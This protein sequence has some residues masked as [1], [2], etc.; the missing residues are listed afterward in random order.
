MEMTRGFWRTRDGDLQE[1]RHQ[2]PVHQVHPDHGAGVWT[3]EP[4]NA[5]ADVQ[6]RTR[7][8]PLQR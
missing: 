6:E 1:R 3:S 2:D 7:Q 8:E 4:V 5:V